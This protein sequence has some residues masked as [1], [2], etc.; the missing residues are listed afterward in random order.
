MST[1]T[2]RIKEQAEIARRQINDANMQQVKEKA[3]KA[4]DSMADEMIGFNKRSEQWLDPNLTKLRN[5]KYSGLIISGVLVVVGLVGFV[6]G[7]NF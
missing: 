5:S 1:I 2:E 7:M 4:V 6:A 3:I